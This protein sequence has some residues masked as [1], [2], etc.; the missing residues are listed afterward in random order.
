MK[1]FIMEYRI[2]EFITLRLG[3]NETVIYIG[4]EHFLHCKY[5]FLINPKQNL[6]NISSID[7]GFLVLK[8][9]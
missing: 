7:D 8:R 9:Y 2:D 1:K 5:L 6:E 3:E 4:N